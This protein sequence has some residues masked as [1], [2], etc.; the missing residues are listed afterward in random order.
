VAFRAVIFDL[1]WTLLYEEETGLMERAVALVEKAGVDPDEWHKAWRSTLKAS[2]RNEISLLGRVRESLKRAGVAECDGAVA[3][4]LAGL[5]A[6]R[7]TP[8]LYPDVRESLAAVKERG[9]G[10]GLVSNISSYRAGWLKELELAPLFDVMALSCEL[11]VTKPE[12]AIYQAAVEGL[13]VRPEECVLV[14]D[15]PPYVQAARKLGMATVR[16]NRFGSD[17]IYRQYYDDLDFDA[18]LQIEGLA[19]LVAWLPAQAGDADQGQS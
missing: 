6:A 18:D 1:Y 5:M 17:E 8:R 7:S 14:D 3:E 2:W 10:M 11:G 12:R 16:I 19:E 15:V 4:E 13:G 9:F